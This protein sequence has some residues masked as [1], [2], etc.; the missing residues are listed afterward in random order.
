MAVASWGSTLKVS[1]TAV[2]MTTEACTNLGGNVFQVTNTVKRI[3]DPFTTI[4]VRDA[5]VVVGVGFYLVDLC[6]GRVVFSGYTPSGAVTFTGAY[7]PVEAVA[8]V[9]SFDIGLKADLADN[10]TFDSAGFHSK[11]A[12]LRDFTVGF[13]YLSAPSTDRDSVLAG[14]QTLQGWRESGTPKLIEIKLGSVFFRG[15]GTFETSESWKAEVGGLNV[16]SA[17][18]SGDSQGGFTSC[19]IGT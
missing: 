2:A 1:G 3:V 11:L 13:E 16:Y 17:S 5:G 14:V 19:G 9:R 7:L 15:W 18:L 12:C 6:F 10:T 8:E 4:V